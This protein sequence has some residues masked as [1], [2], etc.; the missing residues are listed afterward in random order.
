MVNWLVIETNLNVE[1]LPIGEEDIHLSTACCQCRPIVS[2]TRFE[3]LMITHNAFDGRDVYEAYDDSPL[4]RTRQK[5][6]L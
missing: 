3:K 2:K 1:I 4:H 5:R 6:D